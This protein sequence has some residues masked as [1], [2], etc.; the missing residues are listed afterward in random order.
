MRLIR[1]HRP[2]PAE[3]SPFDRLVSL[4]DEFDRLFEMGAPPLFRQSGLFG[5][6]APALDVY[7]EKDDVVVLVELPGMKREEIEVSLHDGLLS[8]SG[9]RKEETAA[10]DST[11]QRSERYFGRFSRSIAL[12]V[13]VEA[14]KVTA[15][16]QDGVLRVVL[17]KAPEAKPKQISVRAD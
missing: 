6:W 14:D 13:A 3:W 1:Y 11:V 15:T 2:E 5:D 16:Y 4:R 10:K 9:E 8:I 12:P 17:P 7:Q